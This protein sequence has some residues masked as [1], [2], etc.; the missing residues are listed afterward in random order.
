MRVTTRDAITAVLISGPKST[1]QIQA[2]TKLHRNTLY[3]A[4]REMAT[5][6]YGTYPA[7]WKLNATEAPT[8]WDGNMKIEGQQVEKPKVKPFSLGKFN[9]EEWNHQMSLFATAFKIDTSKDPTYMSKQLGQ[10]IESFESMRA[11]LELLKDKPDWFDQLGGK[12]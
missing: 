9:I 8:K 3:T 11:T 4:L 6:D 12:D 7:T 5:L 10:V 2:R 1:A